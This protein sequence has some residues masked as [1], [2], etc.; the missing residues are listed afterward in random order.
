MPITFLPKSSTQLLGYKVYSALISQ[1]TVSTTSGLLVIGTQYIIDTLQAGDNFTNVGYVSRG[2]PFTATGTTPTV[3]TNSTEVITY[4]PSNP[5]DTVQSY[6]TLTDIVWTRVSPATYYGTK[7]GAFPIDKTT[8]LISPTGA[9]MFIN[10]IDD[11]TILIQTDA[12]NL[13]DHTTVEIR[14]SN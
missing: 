4:A 5:V 9:N 1:T 7:V 10:R 13:L 3:W 8:Y 6:S 11:D 12:D 14:V 2:V